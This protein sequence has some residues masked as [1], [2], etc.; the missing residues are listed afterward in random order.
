MSTEQSMFVYEDII[1]LSKIKV[2]L[3]KKCFGESGVKREVRGI[4][5][6]KGL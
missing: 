1:I 2:S 3:N 6:V 5:S 4:T